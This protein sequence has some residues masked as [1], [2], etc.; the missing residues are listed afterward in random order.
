MRQAVGENQA[1]EAVE[2]D[3]MVEMPHKRLQMVL[4][5]AVAVHHLYQDMQE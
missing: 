2:Q 3:I 1:A 4:L 5:E